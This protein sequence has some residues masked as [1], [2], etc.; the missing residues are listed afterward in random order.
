M[1]TAGHRER[2]K[3]AAERYPSD[4]TDAEW[5]LLAPLIPPAKAGGRPRTT[6]MR[7]VIDALFYLLRTG[8]QWRQLP[9]DFPPKT[10]VYDYF[11]AWRRKG[12]WADILHHLVL[13]E[14]ER[15]GKAANPSAVILD[16]QSVKGAQRMA[17]PVGKQF[18]KGGSEQSAQTYP[19]FR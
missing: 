11:A 10:T 15:T 4:V 6:D 13:V 1:W 7:A 18:V 17:R 8:C 3:R 2:H 12:V 16:S 14:R 5:A 9:R 19:A